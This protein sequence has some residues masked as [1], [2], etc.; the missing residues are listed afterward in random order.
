MLS[1]KSD[2]EIGDYFRSNLLA[3][4]NAVSP[5]DFKKFAALTSNGERVNF[6]LNYPEAHSLPLEVEKNHKKDLDKALKLKDA[7]NKFFGLGHYF[8]ALE[9]Y[10]NAILLAP[11][12]GTIKG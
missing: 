4:R 8:R 6:I 1:E 7:G 10:S 9:T 5:S 2:D 11:R 12:K 3:V